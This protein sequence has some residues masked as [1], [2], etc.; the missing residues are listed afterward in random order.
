M[1]NPPVNPQLPV[2]PADLALITAPQVVPARPDAESKKELDE[3]DKEAKHLQNIGLD[4]DIRA[5]K[6]YAFRIFLLVA[7]WITAVLAILI[8]QGF[9]FHEFHLSDNVLLAAIGSTTANIIGMLLIVIKYL[10]GGRPPS[11][12]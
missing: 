12:S 2:D 4:Q 5:R 8:L 3:Y 6:K 9:C 10:F 11:K 1:G 7:F